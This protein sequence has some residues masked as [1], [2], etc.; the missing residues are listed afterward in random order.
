M[1]GRPGVA[2]EGHDGGRGSWPVMA[3]GKAG[4]AAESTTGAGTP[5]P[6]HAVPSL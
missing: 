2:G 6:P 4:T 3:R 5:A 1:V